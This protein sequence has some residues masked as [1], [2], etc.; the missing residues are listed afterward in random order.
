[1]NALFLNIHK[2]FKPLKEET[3]LRWAILLMA[4]TGLSLSTYYYSGDIMI[5]R[6]AF[7]RMVAG[8]SAMFDKYI[9]G[10]YLP[11]EFLI[12]GPFIAASHW[13]PWGWKMFLPQWPEVIFYCLNLITIWHLAPIKNKIIIPLVIFCPYCF[14]SMQGGINR[15]NMVTCLCLTAILL[16][17]KRY[18]CFSGFLFGLSFFKLVTLPCLIVALAFELLNGRTRNFFKIFGGMVI[19][20]LPNLIYFAC[21]PEDFIKF[22]S[23]GGRKTAGK[24]SF[25]SD[26]PFTIFES[27]SG[28]ESWYCS[29]GIW[30]YFLILALI[31]CIILILNKFKNEIAL[32]IIAFSPIAIAWQAEDKGLLFYMLCIISLISHIEQYFI[33]RLAIFFLFCAKWCYLLEWL[34]PHNIYQSTGIRITEFFQMRFWVTTAFVLTTYL[35]SLTIINKNKNI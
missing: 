29:N 31:I 19:A 33:A 3:S 1:M 13:M 14:I 4:M 30:S 25:R 12:L 7:Y 2:Y 23:A 28:F 18:F 5:H 9:E 27:L 26:H 21:Q 6:N 32:H 17:K 11:S 35:F 22:L 10:S 24:F 8:G 20:N 16:H 15:D 34:Y